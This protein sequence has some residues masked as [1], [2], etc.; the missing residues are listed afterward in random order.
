LHLST[1]RALRRSGPVI[2]PFGSRAWLTARGVSWVVELRAGEEAR[3]G[4][5]HIIATPASHDR[6][7]RPFGPSA[8]PVGY[9]VRGSKTIYFAGDTDMFLEMAEL[10]GS[11]DVALLPIWGWGPSVGPGHLDPEGAAAAAAVIAPTIAIPIHWGTLALPRPARRLADPRRPVRDFIAFAKR[12][13]PSVEVR[14]LT[15]GDRTALSQI[16]APRSPDRPHPR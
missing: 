16:P 4:D 6:R 13:A 8:D 12:Y 7:R 5:V 10:R 11:V 15:P 1:L 14:L 9:L 3:I 2:A